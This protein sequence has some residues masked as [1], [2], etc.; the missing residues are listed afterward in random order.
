[1]QDHYSG[2][3]FSTSSVPR[4]IQLVVELSFGP[5]VYVCTKVIIAFS[6]SGEG[7]DYVTVV[8]SIS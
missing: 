7:Y 2:S 6:T 3:Q 1:M 4:S 5:V 8:M